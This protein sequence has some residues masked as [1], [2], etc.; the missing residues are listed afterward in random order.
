MEQGSLAE[1]YL[2]SAIARSITKN[3]NELRAGAAVGN[4]FAN[5]GGV[6]T[7]DGYGNTPQIA[8]IKAL[9]NFLCSGANPKGARLLLCLPCTVKESNIKKYMSAFNEMAKQYGI[10]IVGGHSEV[11]KE[12]NSAHFTVN[13]FGKEDLFCPNKKQIEEGYDI[14]MT[15]SVGMLGTNILCSKH[16][17]ALSERFSKSYIDSTLYDIHKCCNYEVVLLL[18]EQL[19]DRA[20]QNICYMHDVSSGGVFSALWQL[21][22]WMDKGLLVD[23]NKLDIKQET[24]EICEYLD[25]NPY[26]IDGTGAML[27]IAKN[28]KAVV[29]SL[30]KGHIN[31]RIIGKVSK[32]KERIVSIN[33]TDK[34][35]LAPYQGDPVYKKIKKVVDNK[36]L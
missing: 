10:Q 35:T 21:G 3:N 4:D 25:V 1:R 27:I 34:R 36:K 29:D 13:M 22:R 24:I 17:E 23:F 6:I 2:D 19:L 12:Y 33:E 5:L 18:K 26:L 31:G 20:S 32:G 8:F 16:R 7:A 15:K 11:S 30:A 14:V 28:G 9:N